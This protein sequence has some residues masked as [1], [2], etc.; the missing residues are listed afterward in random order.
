MKKLSLGIV[1]LF[2]VIS[3]SG[4][5]LT[6]YYYLDY[7]E[8]TREVVSVQLV[9][10][11]N[12]NPEVIDDPTSEQ[13]HF[14]LEKALVVKTLEEHLID[15]FLQDLSKLEFFLPA[16]KSVNSPVGFAI[17]LKK[18]DNSM[19]VISTTSFYDHGKTYEIAAEIAPDGSMS[20]NLASF[21]TKTESMYINMLNKYFNISL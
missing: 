11:T 4:C 20:K 19:T 17:V 10:C 16:N 21:S 13:V 8:M 2:T 18:K 14:D 6:D 9:Y 7:D 1:L 5:F 12:D 15:E 3:M